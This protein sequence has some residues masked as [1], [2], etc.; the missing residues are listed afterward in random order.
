[1]KIKLEGIF[2]RR[3]GETMGQASPCYDTFL[4]AS[5]GVH[6]QPASAL[7][8]ANKRRAAGRRHEPRYCGADMYLAHLA[9]MKQSPRSS[10]SRSVGRG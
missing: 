6:R 4:V 9:N 2:R 1:M 3:A 7:R 8:Q 5:A 10:S